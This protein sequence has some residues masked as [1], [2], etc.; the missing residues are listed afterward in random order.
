MC[1]RETFNRQ[2]VIVYYSMFLCFHERNIVNII[3]PIFF[4]GH[5]FINNNRRFFVA[6]S[7]QKDHT[8]IYFI[9]CMIVVDYNIRISWKPKMFEKSIFFVEKGVLWGIISILNKVNTIQWGFWHVTTSIAVKL[10]GIV[11]R[12]LVY[13]EVFRLYWVWCIL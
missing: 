4:H 7:F 13:P 12:Y 5:P 9:P 2:M 1:S 11:Y 8:C 3:N 10:V 6:R